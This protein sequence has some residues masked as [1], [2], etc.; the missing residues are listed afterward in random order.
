MLGDLTPD[1]QDIINAYSRRMN[2]LFVLDPQNSANALGVTTQVPAKLT[3]LTNGKSHII[4][5][6]GLDIYLI[7]TSPKKMVGAMT[8]LGIIIQ[9]LRYF[10]PEGPAEDIMR[11]IANRLSKEDINSLLG[12]KNKLMR[13]LIPQINRIVKIATIH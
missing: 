13:N 5:I 4:N 12:L 11:S 3:F 6:C 2:Q 10:S 8:P 9:A 1:V 7:H